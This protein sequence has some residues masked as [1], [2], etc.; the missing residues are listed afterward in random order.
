MYCCVFSHYCANL[1]KIMLLAHYR[2]SLQKQGRMFACPFVFLFKCVNLQNKG[3]T[4]N[5][6][7]LLHN[8][9]CGFGHQKW[10]LHNA[11]NIFGHSNLKMTET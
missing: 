10:L 6:L 7:F 2:T 8:A 11:V 9:L 3:I 5:V 4:F 1:K